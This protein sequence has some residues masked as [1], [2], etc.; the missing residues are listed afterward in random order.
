MWLHCF[1][2]LIAGP[3]GPMGFNMLVLPMMFD[4][5]DVD[6][7]DWSAMIGDLKVLTVGVMKDKKDKKGKR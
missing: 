4:M 2:Q 5:F 6:K 3:A 7:K 1:D